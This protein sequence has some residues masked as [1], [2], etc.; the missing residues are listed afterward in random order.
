MTVPAEAQLQVTRWFE[1]FKGLKLSSRLW[2]VQFSART[3]NTV[4]FLQKPDCFCKIAHFE[5]EVDGFTGQT[6]RDHALLTTIL[7]PFIIIFLFLHNLCNLFRIESDSLL[8]WMF[9]N[10]LSCIIYLNFMGSSIG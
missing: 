4:L 5:K 8:L 1:T 10:F 2:Q 7:D 9:V 6:T 3:N